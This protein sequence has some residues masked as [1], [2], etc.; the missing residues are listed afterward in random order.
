M[1]SGNGV[2]R[3][4]LLDTADTQVGRITCVV[5]KIPQHAPPLFVGHGPHPSADSAHEPVPGHHL[6]RQQVRVCV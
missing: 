1:P 6:L 5:F 3:Y 4:V 2:T